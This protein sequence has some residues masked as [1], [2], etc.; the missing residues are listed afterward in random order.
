MALI[1]APA[2]LY[3][4]AFGLSSIDFARMRAQ[5][6]AF[7]DLALAMS[8]MPAKAIAGDVLGERARRRAGATSCPAD[9]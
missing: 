8:R 4:P 3:D 7:G 1:S 6:L 9:I 2:S 5:T